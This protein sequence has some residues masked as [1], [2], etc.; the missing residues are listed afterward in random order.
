MPDYYTFQIYGPAVTWF[1]YDNYVAAYNDFIAW[2]FPKEKIGMSFPTTSSTGKTVSGYKNVVE[3]NP[4]LT[5]DQNTA[6]MGGSTY[7]FNGVDCVKDKMNFILEQNSGT[8]MYFDMGNDVSV[9]DPLSLIRAA[10]LVISANVDTLI[11]S[12]EVSALPELTRENPQQTKLVYDEQARQI[13]VASV[14]DAEL[15]RVALYSVSGMMLRDEKASSSQHSMRTDG[16]LS[17]IYIAQVRTTEG[18]DV[19]KF[20]VK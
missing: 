8:V 12:T 3:A 16:L 10:N 18:T 19:F 17:G 14:S 13:V 20:R 6:T 2:G 11:T 5:T 9:S 15:L 4:D 7:T 1:A